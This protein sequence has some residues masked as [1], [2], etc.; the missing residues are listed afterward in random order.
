MASRLRSTAEIT[1]SIVGGTA[2]GVS[3]GI[4][5]AIA[6]MP[7]VNKAIDRYEEDA[8]NKFWGDSNRVPYVEQAII[9]ATA[10]QSEETVA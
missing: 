4:L 3:A 5:L 2:I 10:E 9:E 7:F 6:A 8:Y 1:T